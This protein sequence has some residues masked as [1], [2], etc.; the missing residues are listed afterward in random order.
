MV[1][2]NTL[3]VI[4]YIIR[5]T[6]ISHISES[7]EHLKNICGE[8]V[9]NSSEI[10]S[11]IIAYEEDH[12]KQFPTSNG[13]MIISKHSKDGYNY[14]YDQSQK[15][16]IKVNPLSDDIALLELIEYNSPLQKAIDTYLKAYK[17][18]YFKNT[19]T[20]TNGKPYNN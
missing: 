13:R 4:K 12:L 8:E 6:P 18:K 17:D 14:Y 2:S 9:I 19:I 7:I 3:N 10:Q 5:Q 20:A 16:K 11:E 1:D 15:L